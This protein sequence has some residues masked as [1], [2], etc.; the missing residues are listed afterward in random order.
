MKTRRRKCNS[1]QATV[2]AVTLV[3][4][5]ILGLLMGS[6][7]GLVQV[8]SMS[9]A[10]SQSWNS[11]IVVAEAGVEEA[12]AH[13]NSGV[14]T[15]NLATNTW[16]DLGGGNYGKTNT[17]ASSYS[18]VTIQ[19][20]PATTNLYPVIVAT[21]YVA[22]P[23]RSSTISRTVQVTTKAKYTTKIPGMVI[24]DT[25][26]FSGNGI[27]TDSFNSTDTNYSTGGL[28]DATKALDHG[29]VT[30]LSTN[31]NAFQVSNGDIKGTVHTPPGGIQDVTVTVGSN[32]T[33]GDSNW[34]ANAYQGIEA[35]HFAAD[36][37]FTPG[38]V[39]LPSGLI[40][41][42]SLLNG[43][44]IKGFNYKWKVDGS[45][46]VWSTANLDNSL[47]VSGTN[48]I[49]VVGGV[50]IGSGSQIY[51]ETNSSL[52]LY[53]AGAGSNIGGNGVVNP[54]GVAADFTYY[55]LPSNT[56]VTMSANAD[57]TG[58]IYAPEAFFTL[59][60]GGSSYYKFIGQAVA[61]SLKMNGHFNF[62]FDEA[63]KTPPTFLGYVASA[64]DEL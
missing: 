44:K 42:P 30:I 23:L 64:W 46:S 6:Y 59:G 12:M 38:D 53:V 17:L 40:G 37:T 25:I 24:S 31:A 20:P 18:S 26:D 1:E 13:L 15:N 63:L 60:G 33:V 58:S 21:A 22:A 5:G 11:A 54:S 41:A 3:L 7:F 16:V 51:I 39:V 61:Q 10:R 45:S 55:G 36:T 43:G 32:G 29:D 56:A 50:N 4:C 2:L 9:V 49:Y 52:T 57:F 62:H 27:T 19:I 47:Y 28:Y 34:V 35:G 14:T 8:Q 48:T